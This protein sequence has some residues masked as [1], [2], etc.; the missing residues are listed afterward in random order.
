[1][2]DQT[3]SQLLRDYA[4]QHSEAAFTELVRRHVDF[5]YSAALRMVCDSHFAEDVTATQK[6]LV[7][8]IIVTSVITP[9]LV[10]HRAQT[11]LA[12]QDSALRRQARRLAELQQE[13]EHLANLIAASNSSRSLPSGQFNELL[14]LRG[15]VGRLN[16]DVWPGT[17]W[18]VPDQPFP[19]VTLF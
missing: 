12:E 2:N 11:K 5:V 8:T 3:D 17:Q 15:Q 13:N 19:T 7:A 10:Q 9:V 6:L 14:R 1:V 18:A 4:E 16:R